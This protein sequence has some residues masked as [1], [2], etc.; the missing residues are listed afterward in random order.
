MKGVFIIFDGVADLPCRQ[1]NG[2][3]PLEA[4][5]TPNID[6]F[7]KKSKLDYCHTVGEG[8]A[9]QSNNAVISL[10]GRNPDLAPRGSLEAQGWG[11]K[12]SP[13]DLAFRTNFATIDD[14]KNLNVLD[15]R[16]GRN[17]STKEAK[18]LAKAINTEVKLSAK[19]EFI[20]TVNHRGILVFRGGFSDNITNIDPEYGRGVVN[21]SPVFKLKFS[22]SVD[23]E[24]NS[25]YAAE[26]INNFVRQSFTVLDKHPINISRA[27]KGLHAA[28]IILARDAGDHPVKLKKLPGKWAAIA[29][30]PL[31][32]G[33][34]QA[35][36]MDIYKCSNI[37]MRGM[38]VY[39]NLHK[40][41]HHYVKF[42]IKKMKKKKKKYDYFYIHI[43]K[44]DTPGHDNLPHE[45]VKML[46]YLDKNLFGFLK[47][48]ITNERLILT[49][50]HT[51]A[52]KLKAHTADPVPVMTYPNYAK[53]SPDPEQRFTEKWGLKGRKIQGKKLLEQNLF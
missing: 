48:F 6:F 3:T 21:K 16:A 30:M 40:T 19:F 35:L 17:L 11:V 27:K 42:I 12:L 37:K 10:F 9:P 1:L 25:K 46:E 52:C 43:K 50:D 39:A 8:I 51:T 47:K 49:A 29:Y 26:L 32:L 36:K 33:I 45:K 14:L 13:G 2:K 23:D 38:D 44:T 24:D 41:M 15:R 34:S 22:H 4:A 28:N 7:A 5:K 31:E 18:A 20:P 53:T